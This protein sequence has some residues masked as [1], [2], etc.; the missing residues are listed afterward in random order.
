MRNLSL[1]FSL[2]C[3]AS[4]G[5]AYADHESEGSGDVQP[6]TPSSPL[7]WADVDGDGLLDLFALPPGEAPRI[8]RNA[9]DG[10]FEDVTRA[11][12]L[13]A[14]GGASAALWNDIDG[15]GSPDLYLVGVDRLLRNM[16]GFVFR[17]V[18]EHAGLGQIQPTVS[19]E[20]LDTDGDGRFELLLAGPDGAHLFQVRRDFTCV[21]SPLGPAALAAL[22]RANPVAGFGNTGNLADASTV[23]SVSGGGGVGAL[24]PPPLQSQFICLS[25]IRD[26]AAPS[27]CI[28]ASTVPTLGMLYPISGDW[29]VSA[30]G[31]VGIGTTLPTAK[32]HVAGDTQVD[33]Q[34]TVTSVGAPFN[35]SSADLNTNLNADL[36]DGLHASDFSQLGATIGT[37]ELEDGSVTQPKLAL[38]SVGHDEIIDGSI[39]G[40]DIADG[41]LTGSDLA[42]SSIFAAQ[43]ADDSV[44]S[45]EIATDA[46]GSD[47]LAAGAVGAGHLGLGAVDSSALAAGAVD[48]AA[49]AAGAV[50]AGHIGLGAV[51][52]A[53]LAAGAVDSAAIAAGAVGSAEIATGAV[54]SAEI[55]VGAVGSAEIAD[56]S[57]LAVDIA[58]DSVGA[59]ELGPN[60]VGSV[61][62]APNAVGASAIA[63]NAVGSAEIATDA[64][65]SAE[66]ATNAVGS[67]EIIP[68]AVGSSQV[69]N[70]SLTG[71]DIADGSLTGADIA[72]GAI[73]ASEIATNA[74]GSAEIADGAVGLSEIAT[75][76]VGSAEIFD[77]SVTGVDIAD[78]TL[79][80]LDISASAAI[81]G[82]KITPDFGSGTVTSNGSGPYKVG[83]LNTYD[84]AGY[85]GVQ[86]TTDFEGDLTADWAGN[87]I[88]VAG[89]STGTST[90]DN[91]GVRGHSNGV[92]VRGEYSGDPLN[93]YA[94]LGTDGIGI[95]ARGTSLAGEFTGGVLVDG[96][97]AANP[98]QINQSVT[99]T[100][101]H[102][103]YIVNDGT[104]AAIAAHNNNTSGTSPGIRLFNSGLG[105]G[106]LVNNNNAASTSAA[107]RAN[108]SNNA[109][110]V[111]IIEAANGTDLEFR[112][113]NSGSVYCDVAFNGG[114]AD[115]AEWLERRDPSE[116]FEPG[117]VVGVFAGQIAKSVAGAQQIMV[118][119]TNPVVVGNCLDADQ[120][121]RE[122][123]ERVAFMGQVPVK[124]RGE[125]AIGDL[126]LPNG[127]GTAR[128]VAPVLLHAHE[129]GQVIGTAWEAFTG[130]GIGLVNA[131]VGIDQA[132]AA[133]LALGA[134]QERMQALEARLE[135][136]ESE[137]AASLRELREEIKSLR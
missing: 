111:N 3:T 27:N 16:G 39:T 118:I 64:V 91:Y 58:A 1:I 22:L 41:S 85:L 133:A 51:D 67:S 69:L 88:G 107:I 19:A 119:S 84:T 63:T 38:D 124:V 18:T 121:T 37:A 75:N 48:S 35:V 120:D 23:G 36:L 66:I 71:V 97:D 76:A 73:G 125:V 28:P 7:T 114:G 98:L 87:E 128:A 21:G 126:L 30:A 40:S 53:A 8:L 46:V 5:T 65:G 33:G 130:P 83:G 56:D 52:S 80:N 72:T 10:S 34:L 131:A 99:T 14:F 17:D 11:S 77:G 20:W 43:L 62:I 32:L 112:V 95:V 74:V 4:L 13:G 31:D 47:E 122:G 61:N 100:G 81:E 136:Q 54:G 89:I 135:A 79:T 127:D 96:N 109:A 117:D 42:G 116:V 59:S 44:G 134:V 50:G 86:G 108:Q 129:V 15:D 137:V 101:Y 105:Y 106:I 92:G 6:T 25:G 2:L 115:Y 45:S 57:I 132:R 29:F 104:G 93:N 102:A 82:T 55:A 94:E 78:G 103:I 110:G 90:G 24:N 49:I 12:G 26:Q 123:H 70:G 68:G 113:D 9:G 60:A